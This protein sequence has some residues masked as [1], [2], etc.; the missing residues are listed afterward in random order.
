M[1]FAAN[2]HPT[3]E[4]VGAAGA[5]VP[6]SHKFTVS[7]ATMEAIFITDSG[8][9]IS[10]ASGAS[11]N[12]QYARFFMPTS[13]LNTLTALAAFATLAMLATLAT[14]ATFATLATLATLAML[15]TL[16]TLATFATLAT[17]GMSYIPSHMAIA[18]EH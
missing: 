4:H 8:V 16:A 17:L 3:V 9:F 11:S 14:L 7:Q 15:A 2:L 12:R 10:P 18:G 6:S 5:A 1:N 13:M